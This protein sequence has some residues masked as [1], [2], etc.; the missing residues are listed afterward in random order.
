MDSKWLQSASSLGALLLII[1]VWYVATANGW[2][3]AFVFPPPA[4]VARATIGLITEEQ[5]LPKLAATMAA[6][7]VATV[8][9]SCVG[10]VIGWVLY[11]QPLLGQAYESWFAA[12]FA[13]PLV[14]LYP[15]FLVIF[16]R[17]PQTIVA[18]AFVASSI[19]VVLNTYQGLRSV[20]TTLKNLALALKMTP[21]Q[22]AW[23][24]LFPAAMPSI[25]TGIRLCLI[26]AMIY[27]VALE[28]LVNVGGLGALIGEQ[29]DSYQIPGMFGAIIEV[30]VLS[31]VFFMVTEA[32]ERWLSR[33]RV[34]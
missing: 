22:T 11:R 14:L 23:K 3:S 8:L 12:A 29:Y 9:A 10:I 26:Y 13:A 7:L 18:M 27:V 15:L 32:L 28:F 19:P 25:F 33:H 21:A 17:G 1:A 31:I 30:I 20:P 4:D 6:T 5:L 34:H 2:V 24:I 16:G